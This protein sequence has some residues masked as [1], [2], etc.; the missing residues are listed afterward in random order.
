M[1]F[2][3]IILTSP[4]VSD[5]SSV[6]IGIKSTKG[7][8]SRVKDYDLSVG[9]ISCDRDDVIVTTERHPRSEDKGG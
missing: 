7:N 1:I 4:W 3:A 8:D 6:F 9:R 2:S 5:W